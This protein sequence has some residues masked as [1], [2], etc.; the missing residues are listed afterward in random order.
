MWPAASTPG[1][2]RSIPPWRSTDPTPLPS[3][4]RLKP[5]SRSLRSVLGYGLP[6]AERLKHNEGRFVALLVSTLVPVLLLPS[7]A[8]LHHRGYA[9]QALVLSQLIALC[10][11]TLSRSASGRR[12][13]WGRTVFLV[14]GL[15]CTAGIWGPAF[16]GGWGDPSLRLKQWLLGL[17]SLFFLQ[18][19]I[20]LVQLLARSPRVNP[21]VMAGAAAGY[22]LLGLTGGVLATTTQLFVPG[23]FHI[24]NLLDQE[25]LLDR[26]TYFSFTTI[27]G[28]GPGDI[29][30]SNAHGERF[31]ILLS[32]SGTLYVALLVGL[33]LG[34]F[35]ASQEAT[36]LAEERFA[37]PAQRDR[38]SGAPSG[39]SGEADPP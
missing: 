25:Q 34:R 38:P 10:L 9:F 28:L 1:A 20:R 26:L 30:A 14:L 24:S 11:F 21:R 2:R 23:S 4:L 36:F 27:A 39:Y 37:Q 19:S 5:V 32:V 29:V 33:L 22:L 8:P 35:I 18:S 6:E 13:G 31:V 3:T 7:T 12:K 15:L 17:L 16:H